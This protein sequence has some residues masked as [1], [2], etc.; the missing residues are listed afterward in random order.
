[1]KRERERDWGGGGGG[2]RES[3]YKIE[4][5]S[6]LYSTYSTDLIK[7]HHDIEAVANRVK[8]SRS[9]KILLSGNT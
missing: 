5:T 6:L 8:K 4:S 9:K 1:M 3:T 7:K 2:I